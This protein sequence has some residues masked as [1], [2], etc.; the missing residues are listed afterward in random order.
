VLKKRMVYDYSLLFSTMQSAPMGQRLS[1]RGASLAATGDVMM[2]QETLKVLGLYHG[3]IDGVA[4]S[5]T[6]VAVR[7]YKKSRHMA[8]TNALTQAFIDHL[9]DAT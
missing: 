2:V 4:G 3:V 6:Y 1:N 5:Q 7:A 9:R 8:P